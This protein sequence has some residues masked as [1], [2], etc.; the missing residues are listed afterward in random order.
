MTVPCVMC[1]VVL[2]IIIWC[3]VCFSSVCSFVVAVVR[4]PQLNMNMM[5]VRFLDRSNIFFS[6]LCVCVSVC[7]NCM[8]VVERNLINNNNKRKNILV[9]RPR[10]MPIMPFGSRWLPMARRHCVANAI[11]WRMDIFSI[12]LLFES[13]NEKF[14]INKDRKKASFEEGS[15]GT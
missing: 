13:E 7:V 2:Y 5:W 10:L 8:R 6:P 3:L 15:I 14:K 12:L 4:Q 9:S 11:G 1:C